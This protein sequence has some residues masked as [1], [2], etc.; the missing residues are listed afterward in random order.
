MFS[1]IDYEVSLFDHQ[2]LPLAVMQE[3]GPVAARIFAAITT[4]AGGQQ[5]HQTF[6]S[7]SKLA[8]V[9]MMEERTARRA[10]K[11]LVKSG[12]LFNHGRERLGDSR[13]WRRTVRLE[14][15]SKGQSSLAP[16]GILPRRVLASPQFPLTS[17][18]CA[19]LSLVLRAY[20]QGEAIES[21][22]NGGSAIG[23]NELSIKRLC[24]YTGLSPRSVSSARTSLIDYGLILMDSAQSEL[25]VTVLGADGLPEIHPKLKRPRLQKAQASQNGRRDWQ[26]RPE[27]T[28]NPDAMFTEQAFPP[29]AATVLKGDDD[30]EP[31]AYPPLTG[32]KLVRYPDAKES[33]TGCKLVRGR[34]QNSPSSLT[35][36]IKKAVLLNHLTKTP[37][38]P[39]GNHGGG[40]FMEMKGKEQQERSNP[41]APPRDQGNDHATELAAMQR[42]AAQELERK[43]IRHDG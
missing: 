35:K 30:Y 13:F 43:D 41:L 16:Y 15:T 23:M 31:V 34:M 20:H 7:Y 37:S 21:A 26:S 14:I 5:G 29:D 10:V 3:C 17:A 25:M 38:V 11:V 27:L 19:V 2:R 8:A 42:L 9:A 1:L 22:G 18:E 6:A 32:C 12:Y 28:P 24:R 33:D 36:P 40:G 39:P 4:A